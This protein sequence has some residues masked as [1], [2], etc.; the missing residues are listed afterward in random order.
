[1]VE[2]LLGTSY[3]AALYCILH[4]DVNISLYAK[5][6]LSLL[7]LPNNVMHSPSNHYYDSYIHTIAN[8]VT[9]TYLVTLK[10]THTSSRKSLIYL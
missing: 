10:Q 9:V 1:M 5:F 6:T 3:I 8:Y 7:G 2:S 4:K